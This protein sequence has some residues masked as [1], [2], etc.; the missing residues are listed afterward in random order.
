VVARCPTRNC[1]G[2]A[3]PAAEFQYR[4]TASDESGFLRRAA[5]ERSGHDS[6]GVSA[7]AFVAIVTSRSGSRAK[8]SG[9]ASASLVFSVSPSKGHRRSGEPEGDRVQA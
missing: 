7:A 4:W 2:R 6:G 9:D 8:A 1:S 3:A 5:N